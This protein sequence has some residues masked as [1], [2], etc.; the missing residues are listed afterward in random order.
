MYLKSEATVYYQQA[1]PAI[2]KAVHSSISSG[3]APSQ[4]GTQLLLRFDNRIVLA[5]VLEVYHGSCTIVIRGLELQET[6][7]H[8]EEATRMDDI[9]KAI[10]DPNSPCQFLF[11]E[12]IFNT[13]Q[14]VDS[15]V[16]QTYSDAR[17]VLT[18]II[19]QPSALERFSSNLIRSLVWVFHQHFR[20]YDFGSL[21]PNN[22]TTAKLSNRRLDMT[23]S[24]K[25]IPQAWSEDHLKPEAE[26]DRESWLSVSSST[27][28]QQQVSSEEK[29]MAPP[30]LLP[31]DIPLDRELGRRSTSIETR[32]SFNSP[33]A[34]T[35]SVTN[36][37]YSEDRNFPPK[38]KLPPFSQIQMKQIMKHFP[39][40]W[41]A[42]L[43]HEQHLDSKK[44]ELFSGL[45]VGCYSILDTPCRSTFN[46][47]ETPQT[48]PMDIY[49]GFCG[50]FP[51]SEYL[52]WLTDEPAV[53]TLALKSYRYVVV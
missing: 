9:F 26:E 18:G 43:N 48:K 20:Q 15:V 47:Y 7:C 21:T 22:D 39:N 11:N 16:I 25:E 46:R 3:S 1:E 40:E 38:W 13:L 34:V 2:A 29:F 28:P 42:F 10:H 37:I 45:V 6:S 52:S 35:K 12:N 49:R 36:R 24:R 31:V 50:E 33:A 14:P 4:P 41:Y 30:D 51:Y 53:R 19:D 27:S 23:V 44:F 5:T 32:L 8:S 17:N